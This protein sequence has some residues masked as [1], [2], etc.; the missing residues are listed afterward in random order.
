MSMISFACERF[1]GTLACLGSS[2]SPININADVLSEKTKEEKD[3]GGP[4]SAEGGDSVPYAL[5]MKY[6]PDATSTYFIR[7]A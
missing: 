1:I 4:A 7:R 5:R 3:S 6:V 2:R